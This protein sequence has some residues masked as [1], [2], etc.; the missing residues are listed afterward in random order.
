M[1][2]I[3]TGADGDQLGAL[4]ALPLSPAL[5]PGCAPA[6]LRFVERLAELIVKPIP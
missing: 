5:G 2:D 1:L 3:R 4:P 6:F